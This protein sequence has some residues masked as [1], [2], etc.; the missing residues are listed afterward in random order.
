MGKI[1][2]PNHTQKQSIPY[3]IPVISR[4][5]LKKWCFV[6]DKTGILHTPKPISVD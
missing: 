6:M 3:I 2:P 5:F 1:L 4:E